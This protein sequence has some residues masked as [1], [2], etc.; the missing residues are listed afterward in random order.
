MEIAMN[1]TA[2]TIKAYELCKNYGDFVMVLGIRKYGINKLLHKL[3][4]SQSL[5]EIS[6]HYSPL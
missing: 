4:I 5:Q 3:C 6:N 1:L 2:G